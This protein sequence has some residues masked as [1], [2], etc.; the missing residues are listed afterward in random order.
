[1]ASDLELL[2]FNL[3]EKEY[4]YFSEDELQML[5]DEYKDFKTAAY[6]GCLLKAAKNDG[7]EVAGIKIESNREYWLKLAEEYKTS[8][9]RVDGI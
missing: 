5:L 1:M 9:K 2:K 8:M 7:I 6:Y 4:P 3:Q